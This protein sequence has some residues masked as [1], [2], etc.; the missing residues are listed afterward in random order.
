MAPGRLG[1]I[2]R[3]VPKAPDPRAMSVQAIAG[4]SLTQHGDPGGDIAAIANL[5]V[6]DNGTRCAWSAICSPTAA[7]STNRSAVRMTSTASMSAAVVA[8][9]LRTSVMI[10]R[11]SR[12]GLPVD[13][14]NDAQ[15]ADKAAD[16]LTR[17]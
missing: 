10:D 14:L 5:P 8:P 1:G 12:R 11:R 9:S 3:V 7:I 15:Y 2:I 17:I 4:V 6:G 16:P 13:Q